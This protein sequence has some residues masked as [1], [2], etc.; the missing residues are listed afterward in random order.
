MPGDSNVREL[1]E[2]RANEEELTSAERTFLALV[3]LARVD[4]DVLADEEFK[5]IRNRLESASINISGELYRFWSQNQNSRIDFDHTYE[6]RT[7]RPTSDRSDLVLKL[8]VED[9]RYGVSVPVDQRSHGFVWFFSFLV[10]FSQIRRVSPDRPL[11]LLLD[12]PGTALH[13][14]A[15]CDF[16]KVVDERL[17]DHQVL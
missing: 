10:N 1:L 13:R 17:S 11:V 16:L 15:Q 14:L 2:R 7:N 4:L 6:P 8:L 9:T 5:V 3:D 12:E